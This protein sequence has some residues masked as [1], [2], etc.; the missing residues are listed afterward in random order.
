MS[1]VPLLD[2]ADLSPE[3]AAVFADIRATRKTDFINNFWR[4][5]A[6]DPPALKRTWESL[7]QVM[8]PGTLDPLTKELIYVAVSM[9]NSCEYCIRS[10]SAAARSKGMSEAQFMELVS[11]VAMA[12]ETNRLAIALQ[13]PVDEAFKPV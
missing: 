2:D 10:H 13:V 7:K 11:I 8:G 6:N 9:T 1:T 5:L 4:A 12:S 3:A